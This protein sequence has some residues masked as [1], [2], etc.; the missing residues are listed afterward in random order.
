LIHFDD[1]GK[2]D[3]LEPDP[4]VP[5]GTVLCPIAQSARE[6]I[7]DERRIL[8]PLRRT[9]KKGTYAFER[10]S[11]DEAYEVIINKLNEIKSNRGPEAVGFYSGTGSYE[12]SIRD[13][14][15]VG[16]SEIY[17]A[18]SVLFPFG[19]PNTF[20]VGA[21]CYTSLG[22]IA[23]KTTMGS[24]HTDMYSD[25]DNSDLIIVWGTDPATATPPV[26]FARL[27]TAIEEGATLIVIDPR[28]T[29]C[30][31][32][33]G[34]EWI[35]IRPGT[36][37]ALA[38]GL[39]HVIITESLYDR[40]F[41]EN[42]VLG[43][44]EFSEYVKRFNPEHVSRLTNI[45]E[46]RIRSLARQICS[47]EGASYLMYTGLEYSKSGVQSI[48][49]VMILWALAGQLDVVGGRGFLM[50]GNGIPIPKER[51]IK[52]PGYDRSV[53]KGKFPIYE[54]YCNEPHALL[55]PRAILDS[56]PYPITSLIILGASLTN[57]WPDP[58]TWR[59][60]LS[61]LEFLV[62]IDL[63]LTADAAYADIVLP[64]TTGFEL[65]SYCY[66]GCTARIRE[67]MIEPLGESRPDYSI[68]L[69][70]AN[71]LGYGKLYPQNHDE[72]LAH[73]LSGTEFTVE[74][75]KKAPDGV[76][77]NCFQMMEYRKWEKG[78]LRADG[79]PGF[80]TPSGKLEIK[81]SILEERGYDGLPA[82]VESDETPVSQP[83]LLERFPLILGTGSMKPDMK[84]CF[85]AIPRFKEMY[86]HPLIEMHEKDAGKR[87]ISTGDPV[88]VKTVR[89]EVLMYAF[90]T[91]N[92]MEG[93]VY[94]AVGGGGPHGTDAWKQ[95][96]VNVLTDLEQYDEISGFP[97]YK[98]LLCEVSRKKRLRKG[99]AGQFGSLGCSG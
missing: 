72:I 12:R 65:E 36:D 59:K 14:F 48:R 96:N 92:I 39:C 58:F 91:E 75:W 88:V 46:E 5:M 44:E 26:N 29:A 2:I 20:G 54:Y 10:I 7:Y 13:V 6:I 3:S 18:T 64:A 68:M 51:Q 85:R 69:E 95:S 93:V 27:K 50:R 19:S 9:G 87:G 84:T 15:Q 33:D 77:R 31:R 55:L 79:K 47:A 37:G 38:L 1:D 71:R 74:E 41:A 86:P 73:F 89:G 56:D 23:P 34:S 76:L 30:A 62:S 78:L 97:V 81:S 4:S 45:P 80:E 42:W 70:L 40:E 35:P 82:Y 57:S 67:R 25:L 63:Q 24:L 28:R 66:Y 43:F 49:G 94:A 52:S 98:V 32:L 99:D 22:V 17:L 16:G 60:A 90:V 11:W 83:A 53:G 61:K 21:P 8:H